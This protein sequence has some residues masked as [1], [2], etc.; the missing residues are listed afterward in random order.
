MKKL[1]EQYS[2]ALSRIKILRQNVLNLENKIEK[3]NEK[4]YYVTD[5]VSCGKKGKKSL[6]T[7]KVSGFPHGE[8]K[9]ISDLLLKR[10][11]NLFQEEQNLLVLVTKVEEYISQIDDLE[12][13]N[14]LTLYYVDNLTWV[15]VAYRMND[16][17]K[18][19]KY[20]ESSCRQ[21]HDR[22]LEKN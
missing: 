2:A 9:R 21:K 4:G 20:T 10:R 19:K 8:Y 12:I 13:R 16:L 11:D 14:I 17:N 22:F 3:M 18:K 15:Q 7:K 5:I 6:G 1:L